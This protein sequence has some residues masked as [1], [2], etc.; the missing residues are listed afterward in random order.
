M[1]E[2]DLKKHVLTGPGGSLEVR[3]EDEIAHKLLM[4][5]EGECEGLG[6]LQAARKFDYSKQRY[7]Q[8]RAAFHE[9]GAAALES[10]KRGPKT[11]YRRTP[12]IVRQVIRHR[13]LDPDASPQVITQKLNQGGW[14]ISIR[15][16]ERVLAEFGLQKKL[17]KFRP[18]VESAPV[19]AQISHKVVRQVDG[20]PSVPE[21]F[22]RSLRHLGRQAASVQR[23]PRPRRR[24]PGRG[25]H[26]P[27]D[28]LQCSPPGTPSGTVRTLAGETPGRRHRTHDPLALWIPT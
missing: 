5:I 26:D 14:T 18:R 8:L 21:A 13:F 2:F 4:L 24:H 23:L 9:G 7:F 10:E 20:D 17:H 11:N 25:Q 28:L 19:E 12:E 6:P 16:V 1:A 3:A 22:G 27:R 15:S